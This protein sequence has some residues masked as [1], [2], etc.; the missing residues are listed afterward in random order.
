MTTKKHPPDI[1]AVLTMLYSPRKT[2][3]SIIETNPRFHVNLLA[4]LFGISWTIGQLSAQNAGDNLSLPIIL[5]GALVGGPI[6][7]ITIVYIIGEVL[8]WTGGWLGGKG[9]SAEVRAGYVWGW[10]PNLWV[11]PLWIPEVMIFGKELFTGGKPSMEANV[12]LAL[13]FLVF[14]GIDLIASIWTL[15][16][17]VANISEIHRLPVWKGLIVLVLGFLIIAIPYLAVRILIAGFNV[18]L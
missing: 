5:L 16:L 6:I 9:T 4:A 1:S 8:H 13:A 12:V 14:T 11:L 2:I 3:R 7:G 15:V 18:R 17:I 10:L